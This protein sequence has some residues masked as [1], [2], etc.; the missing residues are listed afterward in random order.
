MNYLCLLPDDILFEILINI[1]AHEIENVFSYVNITLRD[2]IQSSNELWRRLCEVTG[3][4]ALRIEDGWQYRDH[5]HSIPCV[6]VDFPT[7][8]KA[9]T[10]FS[11][12][13]RP[14]TITILPGVH[15]HETIDLC[16]HSSNL[17]FIPDHERYYE[18]DVVGGQV[19]LNSQIVHVCIQA[20]FP[21]KFTALVKCAKGEAMSES[22]CIN[23]HTLDNDADLRD[24]GLFHLEVKHISLYHYAKGNNI[25]VG[26][27]VVRVDGSN[28]LLTLRSCSLQSDSGRG[29]VATRG[30][31]LWMNDS[32]VHD[33]AATGIYV[34]DR[35]TSSLIQRCDIIRCGF[36]TRPQ[37]IGTNDM[38][39]VPLIPP[40]HSG[41]YVEGTIGVV[42]DDS[43]LAGNCLTGVSVVRSGVTALR[44]CHIIENGASPVGFE[45]PTDALFLGLQEEDRNII[46]GNL[47]DLGGNVFGQSSPDQKDLDTARNFIRSSCCEK[48]LK[49]LRYSANIYLWGN[50]LK[51]WKG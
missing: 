43:L 45:E 44:N 20:A 27:T 18:S 50:I 26:N 38:K 9:L 21:H 29:V 24:R 28:T 31:R 15:L 5:Y 16:I 1:S 36:G 19:Y 2:K 32:T 23:L 37:E 12:K 25:W 48:T 41:I 14:F 46:R 47:K 33:C 49:L 7:V 22:P 6:P 30:G 10:G 51:Q 39:L 17:P 35:R 34:G 13:T 11:K 8:G 40:G 42:I 4:L 3:K